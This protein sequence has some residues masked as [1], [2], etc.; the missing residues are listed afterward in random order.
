MLVPLIV[1]YSAGRGQLER[2]FLPGAAMSTWP[3]FGLSPPLEKKDTWMFRS[4]AAT[5][6]IDGQF[7][8]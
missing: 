2:T 3:P 7:A 5:A 6:M 4:K 1:L 8:G